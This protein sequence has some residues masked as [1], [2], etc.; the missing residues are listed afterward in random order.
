MKEF[1]FDGDRRRR[2][3]GGDAETHNSY[4]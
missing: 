1:D 2:D 3:R 4:G